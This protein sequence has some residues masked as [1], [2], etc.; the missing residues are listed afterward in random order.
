VLKIVPAHN[1]LI[2][3][4]ITLAAQIV[5]CVLA[6]SLPGNRGHVVIHIHVIHVDAHS[7]PA[8]RNA[9]TITATASRSLIE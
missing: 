7:W 6:R 2:A 4:W 1:D 3:P 5:L 8:A 9:V